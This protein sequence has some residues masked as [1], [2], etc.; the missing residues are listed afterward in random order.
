[1]SANDGKAVIQPNCQNGEY[2]QIEILEQVLGI[3]TRTVRSIKQS[4]TTL[5][6]NREAFLIDRTKSF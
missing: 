1:M 5:S 2:A 6:S 3:F 4:Y